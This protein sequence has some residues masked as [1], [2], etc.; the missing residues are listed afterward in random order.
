MMR[1]KGAHGIQQ[2][3]HRILQ[4]FERTLRI[5]RER[6]IV[7]LCISRNRDHLA[8]E[9]HVDAVDNDRR[10]AWLRLHRELVASSERRA[11][12]DRSFETLGES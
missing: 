12:G 3:R 6:G 9:A 5:L 4:L 11:A 10:T 2:A 8:A 7:S 1:F